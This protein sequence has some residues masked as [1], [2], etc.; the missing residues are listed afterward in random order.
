MSVTRRSLVALLVLV[1]SCAGSS[2]STT[3][4]TATPRV[5]TDRNVISKEEMESPEIAGWDA[6]KA[7]RYLRPAFF[8]ATGQQSFS[9]ASA[10]QVQFSEDYGPLRPIS[11][12][13]AMKLN[14]VFEVRYLD[15]NEAQ[16]RFG[17][18]ANSSPVIVLLNNKQ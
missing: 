14:F 13:V 15:A 11:D 6:L 5:A 4:T 9:N 8:R 12:L 16:N 17:I 10:G 2:A 18:N 7:I 1:A 3:T